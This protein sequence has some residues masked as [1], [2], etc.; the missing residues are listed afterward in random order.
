MMFKPRDYTAQENII[1]ECL[2]EFG[3][4]Y[5]QQ[6]AFDP[7]TVDFLIADIRMVIE[8]D[9]VY[10]HLRKRDI[11]RDAYLVT[12]YDIEYILHIKETNKEEIKKILWQGLNK[13]PKEQPNQPKL[14]L[15]E[16]LG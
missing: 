3:I 15:Q 10:G 1:A 14:K 4:R 7:Y 6:C 13:L 16:N 9:G 12:R 11:K 8:A 5:E 2:S